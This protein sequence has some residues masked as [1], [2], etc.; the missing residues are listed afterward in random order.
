MIDSNHRI[1]ALQLRKCVALITLPCM[2]L[3]WINANRKPSVTQLSEVCQFPQ[4]GF[5]DQV[6]CVHLL[7]VQKLPR[8]SC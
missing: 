6:A 8:A 4:E 1:T 5:P 3:A 7:I 2:V